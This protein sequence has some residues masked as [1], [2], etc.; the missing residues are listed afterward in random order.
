MILHFEL[1]G[2][3]LILS[4]RNYVLEVV[5]L[6]WDDE[7]IPS[8]ERRATYMGDCTGREFEFAPR[9]DGDFICV[10]N[11]RD[12]LVWNWRQNTHGVVKTDSG[13]GEVGLRYLISF[14]KGSVSLFL[15]CISV[16]R[17]PLYSDRRITSHSFKLVALA[18]P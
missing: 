17:A 12:A 5:Q 14:I 2:L 8:F 9:L 3:L 15:S 6:L 10:G 16:P 18:G 1:S 4:F 11:G 13:L 7:G